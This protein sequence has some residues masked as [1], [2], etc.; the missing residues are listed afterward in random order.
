MLIPTGSFAVQPSS[1]RKAAIV[2]IY[3]FGLQPMLVLKKVAW[4]W[5]ILRSL[6]LALVCAAGIFFCR[7]LLLDLGLNMPELPCFA[8]VFVLQ[9]PVLR[10]DAFQVGAFGTHV[11][12]QGMDPGQKQ[13]LF[14]T[15]MVHVGFEF[16]LSFLGVSVL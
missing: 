7:V 9:V 1:A 12:F 4:R 5:L 14:E 2:E 3:I 10:C 6:I 16:R 11:R 15:Q 8:F 13:I